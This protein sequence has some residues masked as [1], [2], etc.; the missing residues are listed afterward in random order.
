LSCSSGLPL[1]QGAEIVAAAMI[2]PF[3]FSKFR[4]QHSGVRTA[5]ASISMERSVLLLMESRRHWHVVSE[6]SHVPRC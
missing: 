1:N 5:S 2:E 3:P 4:I 6:F